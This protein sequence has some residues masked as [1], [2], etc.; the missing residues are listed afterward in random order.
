MATNLETNRFTSESLSVSEARQCLTQLPER[1]QQEE[2]GALAVTR[3]GEPVMAIM[4]WELFES[5]IETLEVL[6]DEDLMAVLRKSIQAIRDG[7][8]FTS[9]QARQKLGL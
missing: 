6:G 3:R 1:L 4:S 7:K 8:T 9:E 2:L 5:I